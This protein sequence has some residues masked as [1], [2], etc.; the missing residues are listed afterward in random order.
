MT[1]PLLEPDA[2]QR[3]RGAGPAFGRSD[4]ERSERHLDVLLRAQ[5]R[6]QVEGL[7]D[8]ADRGGPDPGDLAL[9]HRAQVLAV[10]F[11]GSR[12]RPVQAAEHLQ[13][14]GFAMAGRALDGQ[15]FT[16][17]DDRIHPG[18]RVHHAAALWV[19][20]P[21]IRQ[22]VHGF[23]S[24][25]VPIS[26][27]SSA[28]STLASAAAG[29]S[30]AARH[31]PNV[32]AI[33]PPARAST[34]AR[35][36]AST[37]TEAVRCTNTDP[38]LVPVGARERPPPGGVKPPLPCRAPPGVAEPVV[39]PTDADRAGAIAETIA[40]PANPSATPTRP[41]MTPTV[42]DSPMTWPITRRLRQPSAFSVPNSRTRRDT[43]DIVSRLAS[44]NAA[45]STAIASHL[46]RLFARLDALDS[47]PVTSLARSADVVTVDPGTA[48]WISFCT[49]EMADELSAAT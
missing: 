47:D 36:T 46:P 30:R 33:R 8:E 4:T 13:Q 10:E 26:S 2:L 29:R 48:F 37:V 27:L 24:G 42:T 18:Q 19:V 20:F 5:R 12:G 31:P 45:I 44:R 7:E 35:T 6:D 22:L 34:T 17:L 39:W 23:L 49:A 1:R 38:P 25:L 15:P 16:V 32:P 9:P 14:G 28:H 40:A 41:P 21:D 11:H 43:A 3:R